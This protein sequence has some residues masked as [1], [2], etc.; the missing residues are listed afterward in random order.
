M[1]FS[2]TSVALLTLVAASS[3]TGVAILLSQANKPRPQ[4][5]SLQGRKKLELPPALQASV[6]A[7]GKRM[8]AD[9]KSIP[10]ETLKAS[11]DNL[12][13]NDQQYFYGT[14]RLRRRS[15][16]DLLLAAPRAFKVIEDVEE[17]PAG[18]RERTCAAL[19]AKALE[20]HTNTIARDLHIGGSEG[21]PSSS[22]SIVSTE[23]A[24]CVAMF[25]AADLGLRDL[26][27][28]EF[29]EMDRIHEE[30]AD[31]RNNIV[32]IFSV[33]DARFL[34]NVLRLV[35]VRDA[36]DAKALQAVIDDEL[37][38]S[39]L[40]T[41]TIVVT[42]T[43]WDTGRNVPQPKSQPKQYELLDWAGYNTSRPAEAARQRDLEQQLIQVLRRRVLTPAPARG[44]APGNASMRPMPS[45][46]T[47]GTTGG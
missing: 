8:E 17:L 10:E 42:V 41:R 30:V 11:I 24:V 23:K 1:K 39:A 40:R 4:V 47:S 35:A 37:G 31:S 7:Y 29:S 2:P 3:V 5:N 14:Q 33:P 38:T 16:L 25:I 27:A 46:A 13:T 9:R 15:D 22:P 44:K 28:Q 12:L 21:A 20:V 32:R 19:F 34:V 18:I 36:T 45:N 43:N 6:T 26:L